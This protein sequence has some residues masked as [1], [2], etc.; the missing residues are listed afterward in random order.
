[1]EKEQLKQKWLKL[2]KDREAYCYMKPTRHIHDSGYR[3]FEVGYCTMDK[4]NRRISDKHILGQC[5][6]HI[7]NWSY[8]NDGLILQFNMDL[9]LDGY[10]RLFNDSKII[11][12]KS[13]DFV[14]SSAAICEMGI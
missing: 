8:S 11:W 13:M 5:S 7:W 6:D 4:T 9:T 12:W 10:I 3:T 14:V 2:L 1:M